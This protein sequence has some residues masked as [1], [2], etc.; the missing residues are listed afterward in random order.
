ML[1]FADRTVRVP[2]ATRRRP[3]PSELRGEP[4]ITAKEEVLQEAWARAL[5][6][7]LKAR[8]AN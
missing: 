5:V 8:W 4:A 3:K 7:G 2:E 1:C 6:P